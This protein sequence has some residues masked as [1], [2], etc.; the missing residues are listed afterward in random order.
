MTRPSRSIR[1]LHLGISLCVQSSHI[2]TFVFD[3]HCVS[4]VSLTSA[5]SI[6]QMARVMSCRI[7]ASILS[8][9]SGREARFPITSSSIVLVMLSQSDLSSGSERNLQCET[10]TLFV[11]RRQKGEPTG[12]TASF[13]HLKLLKSRDLGASLYG[14]PIYL[15]HDLRFNPAEKQA[16]KPLTCILLRKFWHSAPLPRP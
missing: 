10:L 13:I 12:S 5:I 15:N 16:S 1:F 11:S 14:T 3:R 9:K 7:I 8:N 4:F 6:E 2:S